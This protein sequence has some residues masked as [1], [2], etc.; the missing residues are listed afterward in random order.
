MKSNVEKRKKL[1]AHFNQRF[2]GKFIVVKNGKKI[3]KKF[4]YSPQK[5]LSFQK[6]LRSVFQKSFQEKRNSRRKFFPSFSKSSQFERN[7]KTREIFSPKQQAFVSYFKKKN[8]AKSHF[9]KVN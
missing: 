4:E 3:T 2:L 8:A 6:N 5:Q 1:F 9:S 7:Q